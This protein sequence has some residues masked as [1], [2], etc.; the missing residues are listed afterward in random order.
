MNIFDVIKIK[1]FFSV[2]DLLQDRKESYRLGKNI[3]KHVYD[4]RQVS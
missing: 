3:C 1:N 2:K 4:K